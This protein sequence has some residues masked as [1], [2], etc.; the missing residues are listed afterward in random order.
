MATRTQKA[1][2][3]NRSEMQLFFRGIF[4]ALVPLLI[5]GCYTVHLAQFTIPDNETNRVSA[6]RIVASVATKHGFS[7]RP[8]QVDQMVML[9]SY[10]L[11]DASSKR[12]LNLDILADAGTITASLTQT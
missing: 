8:D 10:N 9:A 3:V 7:E 2:P 6:T 12:S 5:T 11:L 4:L 1:S